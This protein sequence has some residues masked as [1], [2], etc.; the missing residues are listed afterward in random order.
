MKPHTF[1]EIKVKA[2]QNGY[3]IPQAEQ[4]AVAGAAWSD[5]IREYETAD[6]FFESRINFYKQQCRECPE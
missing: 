5:L 1:Q 2:I 3:N 4:I 6:H